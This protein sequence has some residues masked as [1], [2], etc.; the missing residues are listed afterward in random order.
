MINPITARGPHMP[1]GSTKRQTGASRNAS[2]QASPII[3]RLPAITRDCQS[4]QGSV[5]SRGN[6]A[7]TKSHGPEFFR[8]SRG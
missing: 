7:C 1:G 5:N 2:S 8:H 4:C 6:P 3:V